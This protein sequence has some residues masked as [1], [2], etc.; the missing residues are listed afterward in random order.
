[1][2]LKESLE[3]YYEAST[4]VNELDFDFVCET[5]KALDGNKQDFS[6]S[7]IFFDI[8][9]LDEETM[10][11]SKLQ[12][13]ILELKS[14]LDEQEKVFELQNLQISFLK[15][16]IKILNLTKS[17]SILPDTKELMIK[18]ISR[19]PM[20]RTDDENIVFKLLKALSLTDIDID[21][22]KKNR[23]SKHTRAKSSIFCGFV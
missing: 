8:K 22:I 17:N 9:D 21:I 15:D 1:M 6:L 2:D 18:L 4:Q 13:Q 7:S 12:Q 16:E 3:L 20:L 10:T 5:P 19:I 23:R 11:I 14:D